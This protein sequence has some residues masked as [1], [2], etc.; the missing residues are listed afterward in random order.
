MLCSLKYG[1]YIFFGIWQFLAII[2]VY[3]LVPETRGV[4]IEE[5]N[6]FALPCL[7]DSSLSTASG[8]G[9]T[10]FVPVPPLSLF[11]ALSPSSASPRL[12]QYWHVSTYPIPSRQK[13]SLAVQCANFVRAHKVWRHVTYPGGIVPQNE[14]VTQMQR[15]SVSPPT[16]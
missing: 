15:L 3:F 16:K 2:F 14:V 7:Y 11:S 10:S 8:D 12:F 9:M 6:H 4:P 1:I 13:L 5:V